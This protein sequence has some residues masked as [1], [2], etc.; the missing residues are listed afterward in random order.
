[1]VV[2][3]A[4]TI[5]IPGSESVQYATHGG[6][7]AA[8]RHTEGKGASRSGSSSSLRGK[9]HLKCRLRRGVSKA[10]ISVRTQPKCHVRSS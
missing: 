10:E 7:G 8:D 3:E 9:R 2:G 5:V 1:M 6:S 4:V